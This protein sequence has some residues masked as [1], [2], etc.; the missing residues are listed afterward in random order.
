MISFSVGPDSPRIV[1]TWETRRRG[2]SALSSIS[3]SPIC[4]RFWDIVGHL[5]FQE[6]LARRAR[7]RIVADALDR[8]DEK[9]V[10][11]RPDRLRDETKEIG[12]D[13]HAI[14]GT[15]DHAHFGFP[16]ASADGRTEVIDAAVG[17]SFHFGCR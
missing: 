7:D 13:S 6:N 14:A 8:V 15:D 2:P 17:G 10:T 9:M 11:T 1:R 16:F 5:Q 12:L 4:R 3:A